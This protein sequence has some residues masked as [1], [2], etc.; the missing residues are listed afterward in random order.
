MRKLFFLGII[1]GVVLALALSGCYRQED[2]EKKKE[3]EKLLEEGL[4]DRFDDKV[5]FEDEDLNPKYNPR[6]YRDD[7]SGA[8]EIL[9]TIGGKDY[10]FPYD[11]QYKDALLYMGERLPEKSTIMTWWPH[12]GMVMAYTDSYVVAFAPSPKSFE[13]GEIQRADWPHSY[14]TSDEDLANIA[15]AFLSTDSLDAYIILDD[16]T[17]DYILIF[18]D[19]EKYLNDFYAHLDRDVDEHFDGDRISREGRL[20]VFN[21]MLKHTSVPNFGK[22]KIDEAVSLYKR[23]VR[24]G[25]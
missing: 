5:L 4:M 15:Q 3:L 6:I 18:N 12:A 13:V 21:R 16:Y 20:T 19:D 22:I 10:A 9:L 24:F 7:D 14:L 25:A 8:M 17:A 11:E 2:P 1:I 23:V